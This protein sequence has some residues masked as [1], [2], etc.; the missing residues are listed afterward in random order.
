MLLNMFLTIVR[1]EITRFMRIW[2]QTLLPSVITTILYFI[3]FGAFIGSQ[4]SDVDGYSYMAFIVP[5]LI[6]MSVINN[7]YS[8]V[9][10]SFF[11]QK[12][13]R[14]VDELLISPTPN[15]I[16]LTGYVLGGVLRG[17][18]VGGLITA[19]SLFFVDFHIYNLTWVILL[20]VLTSLFFSLAGFTN[21]VFAR[22][23]DDVSIVPVFIL[24]PLTFLGGVFYSINALPPFWQVVS[25]F[26]PILYMINGFRYGFLGISDVNVFFSL[27]ILVVFTV[28]MYVFN[29]V[30]LKKGVGL[31][32]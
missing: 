6:M 3:V 10:S 30:L 12:F 15:F 1:K 24:T 25:R 19:T 18:I 2:T 11:S 8:N 29:L 31:K 9:V 16:I 5:G 7:S 22:K 32:N 14:A 20:F 28:V 27:G 17:L 21:A 4:V 13:M 26:N 23:F